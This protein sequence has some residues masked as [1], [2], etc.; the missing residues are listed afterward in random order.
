MNSKSIRL[1]FAILVLG[2]TLLY[3]TRDQWYTPLQEW[4]GQTRHVTEGRE[5]LLTPKNNDQGKTFSVKRVQVLRGDCFDLVLENEGR[6]LAKLKVNAAEQAKKKVIDLLNR[7]DNPK[8]KLISRD[9]E[10]QWLI[11]FQLTQS[12]K[13]FDLA[14]WLS[15]NKMVYK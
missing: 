11:E 13:N 9:K 7:C 12:G 8:V 4:F 5:S 3:I 6:I 2:G 10:G 14:S 1:L 15:E